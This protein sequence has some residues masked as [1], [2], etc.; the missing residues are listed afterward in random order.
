VGTG[1]GAFEAL[2]PGVKVPINYGSQGGEHIWFAARCR[3]FGG[4]VV[5]TYSIVD[6]QGKE[7]SSAQE[8]VIP[9]DRDDEGWRVVT[10][11][12]AFI[13]DGP[14]AAPVEDGTHLVFHGHAADEQGHASDATGEAVVKGSN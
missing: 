14:E 1:D 13:A 4:S 6:A 10:S 12:T 5:L 8:A 11:L 3:G 9:D 7:V 2:G